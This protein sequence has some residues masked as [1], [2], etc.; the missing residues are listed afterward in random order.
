[1][2]S[3]I[4]GR[5]DEVE[6]DCVACHCWPGQGS[7]CSVQRIRSVSSLYIWSWVC[8]G[9]CYVACC[10]T[11]LLPEAYPY[12]CTEMSLCVHV[13]SCTVFTLLTGKQVIILDAAVL[14]EAGWDDMTH[15]IWVCVVPKKE[16]CSV[17]VCTVGLLF[18]SSS[19]YILYGRCLEP[20]I[21]RHRSTDLWTSIPVT[22]MEGCKCSA[23]YNGLLGWQTS[24]LAHR[25]MWQFCCHCCCLLT[26]CQF[27][28]W[29][30]WWGTYDPK[31]DKVTWVWVFGF[32]KVTRVWVFG[33]DKITWVWV[34][35]S[36]KVIWIGSFGLTKWQGFGSF[37]LTKWH[38][39]GSLD[40]AKWC[41]HGLCL[42]VWESQKSLMLVRRAWC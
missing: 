21:P 19:Q 36:D 41:H 8:L 40:V 18:N 32:D 17:C 27:K 35:G 15:E 24:V 1:M 11:G 20:W 10:G 2:I 14:L 22:G 39:F 42:W 26:V 5:N 12:C 34:S 33:F 13:M 6:S 9:Q 31:L 28:R 7:D 29:I 30:I 23:W 38:G 37:G 16:V 4:S 3:S 25:C